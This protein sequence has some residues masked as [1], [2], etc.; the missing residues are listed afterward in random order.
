MC[1]RFV[2]KTDP[3]QIQLA[4]ELDQVSAEVKPNYNVAPTQPVVTVVQHNG[5]RGL[6]VMR[7]GLIPGWAKDE[8]VGN[9]MINAR[10]ETV[11]EKPSFKR[12]LKSKRCLI[13]ADGFYEW[14]KEG[15]RKTPMFI[16]LKT[17]EPFA[18]AGLYD[19]WKPQDGEPIASCTIITTAAQ[20]NAVMRSIHDRMPVILSK[21][22]YGKWLDPANHEVSELTAL[23]KPYSAQEMEAYPVS[24][25][26]NDVKNNSAALIQ[27]VAS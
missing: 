13:V 27:P 9:R 8:T 22:A 21:S 25:L 1:G 6:E 11:A 26:V 15:S 12:L 4:F 23:L 7:W 5:A 14:R 10:A 16:R 19:V 2:V 18:F 20:E 24:G 17:S 3:E